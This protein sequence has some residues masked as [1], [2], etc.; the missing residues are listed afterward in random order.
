[1][2]ALRFWVLVNEYIIIVS[3]APNKTSS[4]S[5]IRLLLFFWWTEEEEKQKKSTEKKIKKIKELAQTL[6]SSLA[7]LFISQVI[8]SMTLFEGINILTSYSVCS[9]S[10]HTRTSA[11]RFASLKTYTNRASISITNFLQSSIKI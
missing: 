7:T 3:L 6:S 4:Y 8:S 1:M 11:H 10:K 2:K 5:G 9:L